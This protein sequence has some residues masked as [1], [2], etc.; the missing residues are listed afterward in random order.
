ML[1]LPQVTELDE[2]PPE[3]LADELW[4]G[5]GIRRSLP[6]GVHLSVGVLL[7]FRQMM[8]LEHW[9]VQ[10]ARMCYDRLYAYERIA[11]AHAS[12]SPALRDI[13]LQLFHAYHRLDQAEATRGRPPLHS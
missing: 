11:Q 5:I 12:A 2:L 3:F 7:Q 8:G 9:P 6:S 10:L 1:P 4:P 13:A